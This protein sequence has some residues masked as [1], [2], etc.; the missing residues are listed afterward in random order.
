MPGNVALILELETDSRLRS[1]Q[2]LNVAIKRAGGK[3]G[4]TLFYFEHCGRIVV[5]A[6][7][8]KGDEVVGAVIDE[9]GVLDFDVGEGEATVWTEA[10]ETG[11]LAAVVRERC[12]V[13]ARAVDLMGRAKGAMGVALDDEVTARDLATFLASLQDFPEVTGSYVNAG[14]GAVSEETWA[15]VRDNLMTP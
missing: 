4:S 15:D 9:E 11:R 8:G 2:D 3:P 7:G 12:G 13:E 10:G 6:E 1:L 5:D 14:R